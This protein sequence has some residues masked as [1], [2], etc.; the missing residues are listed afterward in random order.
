MT[1]IAQIQAIAT[2]LASIP[3]LVTAAKAA[4]TDLSTFLAT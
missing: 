3:T 2:A 1:L 4:L